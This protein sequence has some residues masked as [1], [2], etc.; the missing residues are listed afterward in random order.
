MSWGPQRKIALSSF[1]GRS[2][3]LLMS[4]RGLIFQSPYSRSGCSPEFTA[5]PELFCPEEAAESGQAGGVEDIAPANNTVIWSLSIVLF[6]FIQSGVIFWPDLLTHISSGRWNAFEVAVE[7]VRRMVT[8]DSPHTT[9]LSGSLTGGTKPLRFKQPQRI[10]VSSW[11]S[12]LMDECC[13][14]RANPGKVTRFKA[15]RHQHAEEELINGKR[16][17]WILRK[18][19]SL[20]MMCRYRIYCR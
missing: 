12:A 17:L 8:F 18:F 6:W 11:R 1:I 16:S 14:L 19:I 5:I 13:L 3:R 15:P 2:V 4:F 20:W 9:L 10:M 7:H